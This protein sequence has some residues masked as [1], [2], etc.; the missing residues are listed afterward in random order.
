MSSYWE[1]K[2]F[3][4]KKSKLLIFSKTTEESSKYQGKKLFR[5]VN[6]MWLTVNSNFYFSI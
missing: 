6:G 4:K 3:S 2:H 1:K 5:L